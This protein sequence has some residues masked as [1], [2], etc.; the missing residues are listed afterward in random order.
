M[1]LTKKLPL[2]ATLVALAS[3]A[4]A[5]ALEKREG[6]CSFSLRFARGQNP[7]SGGDNSLACVGEVTY[8]DGSTETLADQC[9]T[10]SHDNC[11]SSQLP[12]TICIHTNGD[13][14]DGYLDYGAEHRDFNED[15]CTKDKWATI[16]GD[17]NETKCTFPC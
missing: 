14:S 3:G 15:G 12:N 4:S 2:F 6:E 5:A 11:Y 17:G 7:I 13:N 10:I 16:S 1:I 8:A 9:N